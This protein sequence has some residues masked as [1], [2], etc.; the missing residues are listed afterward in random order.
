MTHPKH[1]Y[2]DLIALFNDT[3]FDAY[4]TKLELGGDE[5]IYLPADEQTPHHR[6]VFARG[7]YASALHE[8]AHWCVAGPKR[9]L[10]EDFGYWYEPDGRTR[11]VQA[12]F[13]K[14]EVRPQAYEW[15]IAKSAGFPFT[16]SCDNLHGDFEPDRLAFMN[17]V[18]KEVM[19]ILKQGLPERVM[20]L[21]EALR[22]YYQVE[23]L[24]ADQFIVK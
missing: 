21:S 15:I 9:R 16:V 20:M 7:F 18:H 22:Q 23:P 1:T 11:Q 6:I 3:F 10:L 19:G 5:P 4:N 24:C 2:Q 8:I 17:T 13:E 12:E 14:V